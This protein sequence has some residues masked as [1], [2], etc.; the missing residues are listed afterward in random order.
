MNRKRGIAAVAA[1]F[2]I[3]AM[4]ALASCGGSSGTTATDFPLPTEAPGNAQKG[5]DLEVLAGGDVDYMDPG[6]SYYQFTFM[7]DYAAYRP[8]LSWPPAET[9]TPQPDLAAEQPDVSSDG[10]TVTFK[11]R[12]GVEFA[13]PVSRDVT[14]ADVK[15]AIER[16]LMPGVANGYIGAYM[17][18]LE[19][20]DAANTA[21]T[22]NPTVAPDISGIQTPDDQ[23]IVFKLTNTSSATLIQALSLPLSSPVPEEYAKEFDSKSPSTYGDHAVATGPYMVENDAQGNL[24]GYEPGKELRMVRNPNWDP[25]TDDRP[26]YV[27]TITVK[28]G[29]ADSASA[30]RQILTGESQ[31]NGDFGPPP[32]VLRQAATQYKQQLSLP[33]SGG[34]RY[35]SL[36]TQLAPLNDINVRKAILAATNREALRLTRG[37]EAA[38]SIGSHF[39]PP[40]I[41]GFEEAGGYEGTGVDFLENPSGDTALAAKYMKKAGY[42]SGKYDGN[43]ELLMVGDDSATSR[44]VG[45]IMLDTLEKLGF[46]VNYRPVS[47]EIMYT[48]F[49]GSPAAKV[50]VCATTGWLKDFNDPESL[51]DPTFNGTN[52]LPSN[53]VNWP[54]LDVKSIN[55][56]MAKAAL[57]T[58]PGERAK[59]WAD[60]DKQI[61]AQAPAVPWIWD[62]S[63]VIWSENVEPVVN[64][65]NASADLSYTSLSN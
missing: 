62:N 65:F 55:D 37:G 49:C 7:I 23:T 27:D 39:I 33:A 8:L 36:N 17:D 52:I 45:E 20:F 63:P 46:K 50:A 54:Q 14:S 35:I 21:V 26:A 2:S 16:G 61:T 64:L 22:K 57:L 24:T 34:I 56:A 59:A 42:A 51:L 28:E 44:R 29:Y 41:P 5:G 48:K 3:V 40:E 58:D 6:A 11:I 31:V 25:S 19:G 38:G 9:K 4:L 1:A 30:S 18:G 43:E 15:Y 12:Q 47:Q 53:N 32:S 13:P 10:K 60:I